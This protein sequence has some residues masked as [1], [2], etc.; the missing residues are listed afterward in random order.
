MPI[1]KKGGIYTS[2][3]KGRGWAGF[4]GRGGK[5]GVY[6]PKESARE[7]EGREKEMK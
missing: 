1:K 4:H 3:I 6:G 2:D 5:G 7:L